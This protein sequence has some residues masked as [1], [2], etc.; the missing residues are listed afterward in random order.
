MEELRKKYAE[1]T[2]EMKEKYA[3]A[4]TKIAISQGVDLGVAF[5]MLKATCRGGDYLGDAEVDTEELKKDYEELAG[6]SD[7]IASQL[8]G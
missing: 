8:Y 3:D 2:A 4:I 6:I 7:A 1:K 5:E